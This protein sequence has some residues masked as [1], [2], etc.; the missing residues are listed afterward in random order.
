M[1]YYCLSRPSQ[2]IFAE[3]IMIGVHSTHPHTLKTKTAK[4]ARQGEAPERYPP[5]QRESKI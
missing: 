3:E 1:W 5:I 2:G 4:H